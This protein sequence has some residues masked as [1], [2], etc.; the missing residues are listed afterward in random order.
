M[1]VCQMKS[2]MR[3]WARKRVKCNTYSPH[4]CRNCQ[5]CVQT[6]RQLKGVRNVNAYQGSR[7]I[8]VCNEWCLWVYAGRKSYQ[9]ILCPQPTHE[10]GFKPRLH[11]V[12]VIIAV[13]LKQQHSYNCLTTIMYCCVRPRNM[14]LCQKCWKQCDTSRKSYISNRSFLDSPLAFEECLH[15]LLF[16][17]K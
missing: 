14:S 10:K 7:N 3:N 6:D 16:R 4:K 9:S 8:Q 5:C 1:P 11:R 17:I 12:C 15:A 13:I 2:M